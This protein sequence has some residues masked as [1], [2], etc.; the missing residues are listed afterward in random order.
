MADKKSGKR[1]ATQASIAAE[2]GVSVSTVSLAFKGHPSISEAT[3]ERVLKIA[4]KQGYRQDAQLSRLMSYLRTA[5]RERRRPV[6][7]YIN[8]FERPHLY[9][10][11][12]AAACTWRGLVERSTQ[13][14]YKI[15]EFWMRD[16]GMSWKR[17]R[18]ILRARG[19]EALIFDTII[20]RDV[21]FDLGGFVGVM[22]NQTRMG[23][24]I[25]IVGC[26]VP[27]T[28][29]RVLHQLREAG[30]RRIGFVQHRTQDTRRFGYPQAFSAFNQEIPAADRLPALLMN[31]PVV[32]DARSL[33]RYIAQSRP[34]LIL[35]GYVNLGEVM[36]KAC[37]KVS[38][39]PL[40]ASCD[41]QPSA[42]EIAGIDLKR[43]MVAHTAVDILD[44]HLRRNEYGVPAFQKTLLLRGGWMAGESCPI[45]VV[46][47]IIETRLSDDACAV[48]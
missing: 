38:H 23:Q 5:S 45:E 42:P 36:G 12:G 22:L 26:N 40:W 14:G 35:S 16:S 43:S 41:F 44:A 4:E 20:D 28:T 1:A 17:L 8:Q 19:I 27:L 34:D 32:P 6:I 9:K 13:L 33:S 24:P 10:S 25:H 47:H 29:Y 21:D 37:A 48:Y 3:R 18:G 46:D 39:T 2:A 30:L 7:A 11:V 15:E 31:D